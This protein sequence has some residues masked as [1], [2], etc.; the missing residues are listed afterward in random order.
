M[1]REQIA[2]WLLDYDSCP[3]CDHE[4]IRAVVNDALMHKGDEMLKKLLSVPLEM[5]FNSTTTKE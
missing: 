5:Y 1:T 3:E 4:G 2:D